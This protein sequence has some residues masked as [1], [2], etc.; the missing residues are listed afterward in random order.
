MP[1]TRQQDREGGIVRREEVERIKRERERDG[2]DGA[3]LRWRKWCCVRV[4]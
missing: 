4:E 3:V 2:G 1:P